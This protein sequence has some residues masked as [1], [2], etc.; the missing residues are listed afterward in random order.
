VK[1]VHVFTNEGDLALRLASTAA[2]YFSFPA[3]SRL[4]GYRLGNLTLKHFRNARDRR[5]SR[6]SHGVVC[7]ASE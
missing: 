7:A 4:S 1:E 6:P 5:G 2:N 3:R